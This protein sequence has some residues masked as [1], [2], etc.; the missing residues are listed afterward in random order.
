LA[1]HKYLLILIRKLF[2]FNTLLYR[3]WSKSFYRPSLKVTDRIKKVVFNLAI[4]NTMKFQ[5][6]LSPTF[7]FLNEFA[8]QLDVPVFKNSI[9]IPNSMGKGVITQI[10]FEP[11]FRLVINNYTLNQ[12][13]Y[14]NRLSS[15]AAKGKIIFLFNSSELPTDC[16]KD[17]QQA[18]LFLKQNAS[19]IQISS[20]MLGTEAFFPDKS[21]VCFVAVGIKNSLLASMLKIKNDNN[22]TQEILFGDNTFFFHERMSLEEKKIVNQIC[23]INE[24]VE[25]SNFYYRIKVEKLLHLLFSKLL[26]RESIAINAVKKEDIKKLMEIRAT[27][28]ADLS[29]PPNLKQLS[30]MIGMSDCRMKLLFKQVFG[31]TIY[32]YYQKERMQEAAFL[33]KKAGYSVS[34]A[35]FHLGFTNLSHF[36]RLFKKHFGITPKKYSYIS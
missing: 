9:V 27:V 28:I 16:S 33:I 17:R 32:N 23:K 25:L 18:M 6:A 35:G 1:I 15:P 26:S 36:G 21:E 2:A 29:I 11:E 19:A 22:L 12:D 3:I 20:S 24:I 7:N 34:E 13:L 5:F 30:Q 10:D 8:E 31:D 4:I 14:L